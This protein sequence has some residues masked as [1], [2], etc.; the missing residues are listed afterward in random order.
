MKFS[1]D[2]HGHA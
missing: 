2:R 1:F